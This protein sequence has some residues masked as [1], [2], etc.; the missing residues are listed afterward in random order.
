MRVECFDH[1]SLIGLAI[2]QANVLPVQIYAHVPVYLNTDEEADRT[3]GLW[4]VLFV[5]V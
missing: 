5:C 2:V 3:G 1:Q 4:E